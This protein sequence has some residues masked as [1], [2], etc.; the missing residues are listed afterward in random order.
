MSH[1]FQAYRLKSND[2]QA[3]VKCPRYIAGVK[4]DIIL[5]SELLLIVE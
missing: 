2:L 3:M 1:I 5:L 4:N